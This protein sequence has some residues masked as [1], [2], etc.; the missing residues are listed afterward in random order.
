MDLPQRVTAVSPADAGGEKPASVVTNAPQRSGREIDPKIL[1]K[2]LNRA[3]IMLFAAEQ[4]YFAF[5]PCCRRGSPL[6][7]IVYGLD[8]SYLLKIVLKPCWTVDKGISA[9]TS[10]SGS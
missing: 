8:P 6:D 3:K 4:G 7:L 9:E 1:R 5:A 10:I 2:M